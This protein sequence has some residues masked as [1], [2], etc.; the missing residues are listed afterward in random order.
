MFKNSMVAESV[1][2]VDLDWVLAHEMD[3]SLGTVVPGQTDTDGHL[4]KYDGTVDKWQTF[5]SVACRG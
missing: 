4:L 1:S 5:N 2:D 3:H